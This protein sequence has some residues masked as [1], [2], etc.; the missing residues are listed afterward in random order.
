LDLC[1]KKYPILK[2]AILKIYR[3]QISTVIP[4]KGLVEKVIAGNGV[5]KQSVFPL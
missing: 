4:A 5:T 2:K 1:L 3:R